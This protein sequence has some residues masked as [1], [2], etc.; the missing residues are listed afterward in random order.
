MPPAPVE[1][2]LVAEA[3]YITP[4]SDPGLIKLA[5]STRSFRAIRA[6]HEN[7]A[8]RFASDLLSVCGVLVNFLNDPTQNQALADIVQEE[9][10][11]SFVARRS[12]NRIDRRTDVGSSTVGSTSSM[13]LQLLTE[14]DDCT[15]ARPL[16]LRPAAILLG[17]ESSDFFS[18]SSLRNEE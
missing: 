2:L 14:E 13:V 10:S 6:S 8:Q 11:Q 15:T 4:Y 5:F 1:S 16:L 17:D 3:L 7:I 18:K 12:N 9:I